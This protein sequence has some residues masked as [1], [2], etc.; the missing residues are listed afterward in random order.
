MKIFEEIKNISGSNEKQRIAID[1]FTE[2]HFEIMNLCF[3]QIV[4][5]I[6]KKGI[7]KAIGYDEKIHKKY[8]DLGEFLEQNPYSNDIEITESLSNLVKK[9][10]NSSGNKQINE[11]RDFLIFKTRTEDMAWIIRAIQ[12]NMRIGINLKS[13]NKILKA[14]GMNEI[15]LKRVQLCGKA[16]LNNLDK[17]SYPRLADIKY[18][19]ERTIPTITK[20]DDIVNV[21]LVSRANNDITEHFPEIVEK[22]KLKFKDAIN[23]FSVIYDSEIVSSDFETLSKRMHR[24]AENIIERNKSL[25]IVVFDILNINGLDLRNNI[26]NDRRCVLENYKKTFD[27]RLSNSVI[28]NNKEELKDFYEK[29]ILNGDEGVVTK[30]TDMFWEENSRKGWYKIVPKENLDLKVI[31]CYYGN[32]KFANQINGVVVQNKNGTIRTKA[33]SG[34]K[35]FERELLTK[36][37]KEGE[38]IGKI[39]EVSYRELEPSKDGVSALRFPVF[40]CIRDDKYESD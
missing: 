36:L 3:N 8:Q 35:D 13:Y 17:L 15:K 18:D 9:L 5:G 27:L 33:S 39:V 26:Q 7:A 23:G 21:V 31:D 24:K 2:E 4:Y 20:N 34:I 6:S 16:Y 11:L 1:K 37:H 10:Q 40:V 29:A 32:G 28:V 25:D 30:D 19:G 12:K 14:K 22:L 38:L